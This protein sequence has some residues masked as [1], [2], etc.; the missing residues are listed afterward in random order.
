MHARPP[1]PAQRAFALKSM[2]SSLELLPTVPESLSFQGV[3]WVVC[4]RL[5]LLGKD[6]VITF[7]NI[8]SK[9]CYLHKAQ[10]LKVWAFKV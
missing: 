9:L 5:D 10:G 6:L 3:D 7:A 2:L 4:L 1:S 8:F